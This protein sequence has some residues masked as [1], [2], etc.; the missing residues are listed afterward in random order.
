MQLKFKAGIEQ[1]IY[2]LLILG[3][4]PNEH[5]ITSDDI[6]A[7]LRLSP[8]YLKKLMKLLVHEGLL[9]SSTGKNGGFSLAKPLSEITLSNVFD[10]I[11]GR[12]ALY[13]DTDLISN[14]T[15]ENNNSKKCSIKLVMDTIENDWRSQLKQVTLQQLEEEIMKDFNS[16]SIDEW[17]NSVIQKK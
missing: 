15:G 8:S 14:L 3:R 4:I 2:I 10:A 9:I 11:E 13:N 6:S 16:N 12:G 5:A 17:I 7:R 1:S